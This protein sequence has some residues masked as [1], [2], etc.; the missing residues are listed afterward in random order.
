ML[1]GAIALKT[2]EKYMSDDFYEA[3]LIQIFIGMFVGALVG[4]LLGSI[5]KRAGAGTFLGMFL[6][7]IG[8]IIVFLLPRD[9]QTTSNTTPSVTNQTSTRTDPKPTS[10]LSTDAYKIWLGTVNEC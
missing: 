10:D 8:W 3:V 7:P 6:G 9:N 1:T 5:V 2:R 4:G